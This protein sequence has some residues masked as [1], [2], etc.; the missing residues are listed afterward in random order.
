MS[1]IKTAAFTLLLMFVLTSP[2]LVF[3]EE[4]IVVIVNNNTSTTSL[5]AE[6]I[7]KIFLSRIKY[8][9]DSLAWIIID[10]PDGH[11]VKHA[12]YKTATR[13]NV[14][15]LRAYRV[16]RAFSGKMKWPKVLLDANQV[17]DYVKTHKN[18]IAYIHKSKLDSSVRAIYTFSVP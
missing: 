5:S 6:E 17:K 7:R 16:K 9:P 1:K 18:A 8:S 15:A 14:S 3:A 10:Y 12:F 11:I 13:K 2:A 4:D